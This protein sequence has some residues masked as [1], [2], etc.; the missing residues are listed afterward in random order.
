MKIFLKGSQAGLLPGSQA[1]LS[2]RTG[3]PYSHNLD[4]R[5]LGITFLSNP[6]QSILDNCEGGGEY[7]QLTGGGCNVDCTLYVHRGGIE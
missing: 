2:Q 3:F 7:I 1:A 6:G 4:F 5:Y